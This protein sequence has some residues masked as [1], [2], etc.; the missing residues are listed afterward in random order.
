MGFREYPGVVGQ[1]LQLESDVLETGQGMTRADWIVH[2]HD[3]SEMCRST[4]ANFF[5]ECPTSNPSDASYRSILMV[6]RWA[7]GFTVPLAQQIGFWAPILA[8]HRLHTAYQRSCPWPLTWFS[9]PSR[10]CR[11]PCCL[12][13]HEI[14]TVIFSTTRAIIARGLAGLS[15]RLQTLF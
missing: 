1:G 13:C 3:D 2:I 14:A 12:L 6:F 4:H 11:G 9:S 5:L 7:F 8:A 10:Y 15:L